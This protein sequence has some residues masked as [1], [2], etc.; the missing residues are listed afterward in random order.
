MARRSPPWGAIE[1]FIAASGAAS[2][3]AAAS[4]IGLSPAAFSRRIR[5]L[6]NHVKVRLF[7]RAAPV[8]RLTAAGRRYLSRLQPGYE[9][10]RAATEWM[11]P[12]PERRPLRV[13]V[14]QSIAVSWLLPRLARFYAQAGGIDLEFHTRSARIDL[15][16]GAAD[17]AIVYG[18]GDWKGLSFQKLFE[19]DAFVVVGRRVADGRASPSHITELAG[20]RLLELASPPNLWR[21]WLTRAGFP[22]LHHNDRVRFD[23]AQVMY[24]SA[25][26]GH[27]VALGIRPLVDPLLQEGRLQVAFDRVHPLPGALYVAALPEIRR[28]AAVASFWN[29]VTAEARAA[30]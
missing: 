12:A 22:Q 2:F 25:A 19:L 18:S 24:E 14:S 23:S 17:V 26:R 11:T 3:R 21:D 9:A 16:G 6:E 5:A 4:D 7:D 10:I 28:R 27:G 15:A 30:A 8:P 29:W 1:A 20:H 13:G